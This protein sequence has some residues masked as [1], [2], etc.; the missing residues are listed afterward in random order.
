RGGGE[1]QDL[2]ASGRGDGATPGAGGAGGLG[3]R[4]R[5]DHRNAYREPHRGARLCGAP[6]P[7]APGVRRTAA[8]RARPLTVPRR[9]QEQPVRLRASS[10]PPSAGRSPPRPDVV[11]L[12]QAGG[13]GPRLEHMAGHLF[14]VPPHSRATATRV[15]PPPVPFGALPF[16]QRVTAMMAQN[17]GD[18]LPV[19][20]F[21]VDG[22]PTR[23]PTQL[24]EPLG[25][26]DT[27]VPAD[28]G[29]STFVTSDVDFRGTVRYAA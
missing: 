13:E 29:G 15:R 8:D 17:Q 16:V 20:A 25:A 18:L 11:Q 27:T 6:R 23:S 10:T 22:A 12:H 26:P 24:S 9:E 5:G 14:P 4:A 1:A 7:N 21:P 3:A 28:P 19:S 2:D